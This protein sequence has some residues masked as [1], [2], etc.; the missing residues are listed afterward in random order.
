MLVMAT[1]YGPVSPGCT[2]VREKTEVLE[3]RVNVP[4]G[5]LVTPLRQRK[6]MGRVPVAVMLKS[7]RAPAASVRPTGGWVTTGFT[8]TMRLALL[9]TRELISSLMATE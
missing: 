2:L 8:L 3:L 4:L 7:A 6:V 5:M 1:L 9:L